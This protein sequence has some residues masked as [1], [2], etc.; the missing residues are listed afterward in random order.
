[1]VITGNLDN[2]MRREEVLGVDV[3][4]TTWTLTAG[5]TLFPGNP[6]SGMGG[7][8]LRGG[9]GFGGTSAE[10]EVAGLN[11]KIQEG[12][13]AGVLGL[14]YEF[15]VTPMFALGVSANG[16]AVG[17]TSDD[18]KSAQFGSFVIQGNWYFN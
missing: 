10:F 13:V 16:N 15:R 5:A 17:F 3:T 11:D 7:F 12:G 9:I 6:E 4:L 14:G 1:M 18:I 8:F 2:W